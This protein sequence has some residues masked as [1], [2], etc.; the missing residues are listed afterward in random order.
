MK[1]L[2]D[3]HGFLESQKNYDNISEEEWDEDFLDQD[4]EDQAERLY[5][6]DYHG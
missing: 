6:T 5:E 2:S 4:L 3:D 1:P